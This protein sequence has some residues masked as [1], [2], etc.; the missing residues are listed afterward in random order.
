M[1]THN[2]GSVDNTDN[3][4]KSSSFAVNH[5]NLYSSP[6]AS[7]A[8]ISAFGLPTLIECETPGAT[9][10]H[11][12]QFNR[13]NNQ[14][15]RR[16]SSDSSDA[17]QQTAAAQSIINAYTYRVR[18][19]AITT[20]ADDQHHLIITQNEDGTYT[21]AMDPENNAAEVYDLRDDDV[22]ES[23]TGLL[24]AP[25][26]RTRTHREES[27]VS[28]DVVT[29]LEE[30]LNNIDSLP[31]GDHPSLPPEMLHPHFTKT[32]PPLKLW[33]LAVLV[34]YSELI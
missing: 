34:F 17:Q 5:P 22:A 16:Q 14:S 30:D 15:H 13:S 4:D 32:A 1:S 8:L 18:S 27:S 3:R 31:V 24:M 11:S 20:S 10:S 7:S 29:E 9:P 28:L 23:D 33:P 26:D 2:Y 12:P 25:Q 19:D 6:A 21:R